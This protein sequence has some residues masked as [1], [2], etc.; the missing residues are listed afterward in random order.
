MTSALDSRPGRAPFDVDPDSSFET[1]AHAAIELE[2][3]HP[4]TA[5]RGM[6][7]DMLKETAL[8]G[9]MIMHEAIVRCLVRGDLPATYRTSGSAVRTLLNRLSE[10]QSPSMARDL[11]VK[12]EAAD[13]RLNNMPVQPTIYAQYMVDAKDGLGPDSPQLHRIIKRMREYCD[14]KNNHQDAYRVDTHANPPQSNSTARIANT[15][16]FCDALEERLQWDQHPERRPLAEI[17]YTQSLWKRLGDHRAHRGS[18]KVMNLFESICI[19]EFGET[20]F[21]VDQHVVA[22]LENANQESVMEAVLARMA[23]AY[24]YSGFGFNIGGA[25]GSC[26]SALSFTADEYLRFA[27]YNDAVY[28]ENHEREASIRHEIMQLEVT[29]QAGILAG[30]RFN[31]EKDMQAILVAGKGKGKLPRMND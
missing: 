19:D 27:N 2:L 25:G 22:L 30:E 5:L 1:L 16:R 17:G 7:E 14:A 26:T 24:H 28:L 11:N 21:R 4:N 13:A 20:K 8:E 6:P 9:L 12:G 31:L 23:N 15:L 18:T 29:R 3:R 10:S